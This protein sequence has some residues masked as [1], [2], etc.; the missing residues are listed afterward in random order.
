MIITAQGRMHKYKDSGALASWLDSLETLPMDTREAYSSDLQTS[1]WVSPSADDC[2][3]CRYL[4][5]VTQKRLKR[6]RHA[7]GIRSSIRYLDDLIQEG[8]LGLFPNLSHKYDLL[9]S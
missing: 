9:Q 1:P 6:S 3:E 7:P 4:D 2:E 8:D 5:L